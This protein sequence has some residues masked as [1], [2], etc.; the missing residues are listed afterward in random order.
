MVTNNGLVI[1]SLL[2]FNVGKGLSIEKNPVLKFSDNEMYLIGHYIS[3][4]LNKTVFLWL[5]IQNL[6]DFTSSVAFFKKEVEPL[7]TLF[8]I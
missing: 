1:D 5:L 6:A 2:K 3:S 8:I 7:L 4:N